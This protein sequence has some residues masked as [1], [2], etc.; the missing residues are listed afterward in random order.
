MRLLISARRHQQRVQRVASRRQPLLVFAQSV[1]H[2]RRHAA[3]CFP[4]DGAVRPVS[5]AE[6]ERQETRLVGFHRNLVFIE[7]DDVLLDPNRKAL[8]LCAAHQRQQQQNAQQQ[9]F[10]PHV[11]YVHDCVSFSLFL[12]PKSRKIGFCHFPS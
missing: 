4:R 8:G 3:L 9:S 10:S 11:A 1:P 7:P 12:N 2:E 5:I 6:R